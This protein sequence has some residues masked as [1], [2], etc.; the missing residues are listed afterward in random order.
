MEVFRVDDPDRFPEGVRYGLVCV[1]RKTGMRVL[2]DDHHPKG[3]HQHVGEIESPY[4]YR[5]LDQLIE[6]FQYLV[7]S[8]VGVEL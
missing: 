8:E 2:M 7:S 3:H 1:D 5:G 4:E 6:D